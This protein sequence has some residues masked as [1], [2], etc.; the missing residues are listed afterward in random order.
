MF[1]VE[2]Q[3]DDGKWFVADNGQN[4]DAK[5]ADEMVAKLRTKGFKAR[6]GFND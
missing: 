5:T 3:S 2:I 6:A 4:V 1:K